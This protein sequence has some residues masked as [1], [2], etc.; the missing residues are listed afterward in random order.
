M[1]IKIICIGKTLKSYLKEAEV[2]YLKRLN[3]YCT[4]EKIEISD[5]R[6]N[7]KLLQNEIKNKEGKLI[8]D[9]L[10]PGDHLILL[11][12]NGVALSSVGF[13]NYLQKKFNTGLKT[14]AFAIGGPYGFSDEVYSKSNYMLSLSNMTYSHQ[15]VRMIFLEQLYRAFTI[16]KGEPYHHK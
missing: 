16:L 10:K 5:L 13:S 2:E 8:L 14:I 7:K 3:H 12:E 6:N 15:M 11:D 1:K 9:A 4:I